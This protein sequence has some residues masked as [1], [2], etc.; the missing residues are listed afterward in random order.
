MFF[1][2]FSSRNHLS[3]CLVVNNV[4]KPL[5]TLENYVF[6]MLFVTLFSEIFASL[7][8]LLLIL[9]TVTAHRIARVLKSFCAA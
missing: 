2:L 3:G 7:L 6:K 8:V 4:F 5:A 1:K 9:F